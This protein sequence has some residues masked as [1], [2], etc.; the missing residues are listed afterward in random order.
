MIVSR[1]RGLAR[2]RVD[3]FILALLTTVG[4]A[5]LLPAEGSAAPVFGDASVLA[6]GLLFFL[7]GARL[8]AEA[9]LSAARHWRLHVVVLASTFVLFPVLG[10][11]TAVLMPTVLTPPLY[12]GVLFL[13]TLPSTVQSSIAFTSIAGGNVPA[14]ICSASLSN[15][16]GTLLTPALVGLLLTTHGSGFSGQSLRDIALQL[17]SPFLAGQLLRRWIG[18]WIQRHRKILGLVDRGSILLVVYT[19]FSAG[20]TA[21]IWHQLSLISLAALLVVALALLGVVLTVTALA[22]RLPGRA[23]PVSTWPRELSWASS[24]W[25]LFWRAASSRPSRMS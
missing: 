4:I 10:L 22:S 14:A 15:L 13:C 20:V 18:G 21:G 2:L 24:L 1:F 3:P 16:L 6:V 23:P 7:Y 25:S 17:L 9:M 8:S 5:T 19:A 11:C 12:V